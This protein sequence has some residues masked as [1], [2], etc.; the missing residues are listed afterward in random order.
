MTELTSV[1]KTRASGYADGG[2]V[3]RAVLAACFLVPL[4]VGSALFIGS[5]TGLVW[6]GA[7]FG[8]VVRG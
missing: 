3:A 5:F 1:D 8:L 2:V 7:I 6:L 4:G